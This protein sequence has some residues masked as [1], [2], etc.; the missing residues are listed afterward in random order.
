MGF[1]IKQ[2]V[3]LLKPSSIEYSDVHESFSGDNSAHTWQ[4]TV[5]NAANQLANKTATVLLI[6]PSGVKTIDRNPVSIE[7]SVLTATL[8]DYAYSEVGE[9]TA[10]MR[11]HATGDSAEEFTLAAIRFMVTDCA[12]GEIHLP[13]TVILPISE[14][15][16][17][18]EEL[19]RQ[20]GNLTN[21]DTNG[22]NKLI[23][24][25]TVNDK[26]VSAASGYTLDSD[27]ENWSTDEV[28]CGKFIDGKT[29][30]K[31]TFVKTGVTGV[32]R[33]TDV[34]I[35]DNLQYD[36]V[37]RMEGCAIQNNGTVNNIPYIL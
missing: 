23:A 6:L 19:T 24:A 16:Q 33:D 11:V 18:Y 14:L 20:Y 3:N 22:I 26:K 8:S 15:M 10:F 13:E 27:Y 37:L 31:K 32:D 12:T 30:Y 5:M 17:K 25:I 36:K 4:V 35:A 7:G 2:T 21:L 28:A 34:N 9:V 29:V 1:L